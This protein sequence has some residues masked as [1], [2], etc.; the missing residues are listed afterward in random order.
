MEH[1]SLP[2]RKLSSQELCRRFND[3]IASGFSSLQEVVGRNEKR[4]ESIDLLKSGVAVDMAL[5]CE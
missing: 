4:F 5:Y 1:I 2:L 3:F